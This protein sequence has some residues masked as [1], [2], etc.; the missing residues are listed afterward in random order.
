MIEVSRIEMI[1]S[2]GNMMYGNMYGNMYRVGVGIGR[3]RVRH[4]KNNRREKRRKP[5]LRESSVSE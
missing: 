5:P 4:W 1:L 2:G 3:G